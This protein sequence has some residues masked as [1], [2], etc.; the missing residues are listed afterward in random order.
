MLCCTVLYCINVY[1][2]IVPTHTIYCRSGDL[3]ASQPKA[4]GSS[5]IVQLSNRLVLHALKLSGLIDTKNALILPAATGMGHV[6]T[7]LALRSLQMK[8]KPNARYV[9]WPRMDQ[10]TCLK[11][12]TTA[13]MYRYHNN[14]YISFHSTLF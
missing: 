10:K 7:L 2:C 5:L 14:T 13:G 12:I 9:L 6:H 4:A 1:C 8:S 11:A 3:T